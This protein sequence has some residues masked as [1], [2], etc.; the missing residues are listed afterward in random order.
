MRV[1]NA[2]SPQKEDHWTYALFVKH[3]ELFL[4]ALESGKEAAIAQADSLCKVL[5]E[6][7]VSQRAKILDL[8]CGIG[9]HS[10][11]LARRGYEV[12]GYDLSPKYIN[13]A[14]KWAGIEGLHENMLRFY[15]GDI[16]DVVK[17][18]SAEGD[19]GFNV[20]INMENFSWLFL[21]KSR[22]FRRLKNSS[23]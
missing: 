18:L 15:Q 16:R 14:R 4:P 8:A 21:E 17:V 3:P 22:T 11:P 12:V 20:I 19:I 10:I 6:L 13:Y 1:S 9:R 2:V 5:N 7:G 23:R